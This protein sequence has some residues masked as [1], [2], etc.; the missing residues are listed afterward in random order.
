VLAC[1]GEGKSTRPPPTMSAHASGAPRCAS[2]NRTRTAGTRQH[3]RLRCGWIAVQ[4]L[5][6]FTSRTRG[7]L[8]CHVA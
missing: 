3:Q 6:R 2:R 1:Y 4:S 8:I 5:S 7:N